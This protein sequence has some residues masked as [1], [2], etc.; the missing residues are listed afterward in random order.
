M[1]A[2]IMHKSV[3]RYSIISFEAYAIFKKPFKE[4]SLLIAFY[5]YE[6]SC[7]KYHKHGNFLH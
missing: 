2:T 3:T 5:S 4:R 1:A 7:I 6:M